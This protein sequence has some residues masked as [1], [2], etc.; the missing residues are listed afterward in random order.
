MRI[1]WIGR[2]QTRCARYACIWRKGIILIPYRPHLCQISF[3][4]ASIAELALGEK[5]RTQSLTHSVTQSAHLMPREPKLSLRNNFYSN[6]ILTV[7]WPELIS[8]LCPVIGIPLSEPKP[9]NT[10][11][12]FICIW[13]IISIFIF[14]LSALY[15]VVHC[16]ICV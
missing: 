11:L 15:S 14:V 5:S 12:Q 7:Q 9:R 3:L 2:F 10:A 6:S 8:R 13:L 16:L 1:L 4:A